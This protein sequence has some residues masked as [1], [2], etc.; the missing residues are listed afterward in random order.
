MKSMTVQ[1]RH[2]AG[3]FVLGHSTESENQAVVVILDENITKEFGSF[4]DTERV[5]VIRPQSGSVCVYGV[6]DSFTGLDTTARYW[7][8]VIERGSMTSSYG[9]LYHSTY[10]S[11]AKLSDTKGEIAR[12]R[13]F[14]ADKVFVFTDVS[15]AS[16]KDGEEELSQRF[17]D[18]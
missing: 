17:P 5:N 7:I 6:A 18:L 13:N 2:L 4:S 15:G 12:S 1:Q 3:K 16:L 11:V 9:P 8:I 10:L 14:L